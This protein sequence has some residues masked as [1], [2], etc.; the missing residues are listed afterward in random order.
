MTGGLTVAKL[1]KPKLFSLMLNET[2]LKSLKAISEATMIPLAPLIRLGI[3]LVIE[4]YQGQVEK[5]KGMRKRVRRS[6]A[7]PPSR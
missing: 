6:L 1:E 5:A 7:P 3:D 2:Q 4:R